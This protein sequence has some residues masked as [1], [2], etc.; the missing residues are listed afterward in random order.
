MCGFKSM[1]KKYKYVMLLSPYV[2]L[3]LA[4]LSKFGHHFSAPKSDYQFLKQPVL[5]PGRSVI[6]FGIVNIL[7]LPNKTCCIFNSIRSTTLKHILKCVLKCSF[8]LL[9]LQ[10]CFSCMVLNVVL[11]S[12]IFL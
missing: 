3:V 10:S 1:R 12:F 8:S 5:S 7:M 6:E 9:G 2:I 4:N 11:L